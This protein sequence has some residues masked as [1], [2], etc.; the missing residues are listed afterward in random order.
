VFFANECLHHIE[1]FNS[2]SNLIIINFFIIILC[3]INIIKVYLNV[4][5]ET[6]ARWGCSK[7]LMKWFLL[8]YLRKLS[9]RLGVHIFFVHKA[10]FVFIKVMTLW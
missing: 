10:H 2:R 5:F 3:H 6:F 4:W 7:N 8:I 9:N 1:V